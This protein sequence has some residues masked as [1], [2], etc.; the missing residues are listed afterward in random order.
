MSL[1]STI[2][3]KLQT[4]GSA[5]F[6]KMAD[7]YLRRCRPWPLHS[8][9]LM[10]GA[11]K[12]KTGVP[13]SYC[14]LDEE[15]RYVLVAY[16]TT[17]KG[18]LAAKLAK[19]L[20]DCITEAQRELGPDDVA[21]I[22]LVCNNR[23]S[24]ATYAALAKQAHRY[25]FEFIGVD[26]LVQM[27]LDYPALAIPYLDLD[28]GRGQLLQAPEFVAAYGSQLGATPLT[29]PL[30]GRDTEQQQLKAHLAKQEVVLV[31][32]AAGVGKTQLVVTVAQA[33]C[34][35]HPAHRQL[36]FVHDKN[37]PDF[38]K[39]LQFLFAPGKELVV[40]A[41]DANRVSPHLRT[42]LAEQRIRPA[43]QLKIVA[44]VRDYARDVVRQLTAES[45][46]TELHLDRLSNEHITALLETY[47]IRNAAYRDRIL[48]LSQGRPRLAVMAAIAA[49]KSQS[50]AS[51][52]DIADIYK[53]YFGPILHHLNQQSNALLQQKALALLHL[54]GSI[55]RDD[56]ERLDLIHHAFGISPTALW[57]TLVILNSTE[58]AE[59]LEGRVARPAD[60]ILSNYLFYQVFFGDKP[61]LSF[62][63]LLVSF[64]PAWSRRIKDA[65]VP[66]INDFNHQ[67][68]ESKI[69][70]ALTN[71]LAQPGIE[72]KDR[73]LFYDL[74]W[75]YLRTQILSSAH[76]FLAGL[77]WL[78]QPITAYK[79]PK[80]DH[81]PYIHKS[82]VL[83][84]LEP[85][86]ESPIDEQLL[87][88]AL[89][90]ELAA[91]LPEQF[92]KVVGLLR[93]L[94]I[95]DGYE[96]GQHRLHTPEL[97]L[98][99]LADISKDKQQGRFA[100]WLLQYVVP[101]ALATAT[102]GVRSGVERGSIAMCMYTV[103][104]QDDTKEWR[105]Q[106]WQ[107]FNRLCAG[108]PARIVEMFGAYLDQRQDIAYIES[109]GSELEYN[110]QRWD[111]HFILPLLNQLDPG[112]FA[113]SRLV[114][115]YY[116]WLERRTNIPEVQPL[117]SR[118]GKGLVPLYDL[119]VFWQSHRSRAGRAVSR[120][121]DEAEKFM[122]ERLKPLAYKTL[123]PY[124]KLIARIHDLV[125][126]LDPSE[127]SQACDAYAA[128]LNEVIIRDRRLG[129]AVLRHLI[130]TG[131]PL[132]LT[133]WKALEALAATDLETG[134]Q[135][136]TSYKY[137]SRDTW[138][139]IFTSRL[140]AENVSKRWLFEL[141]KVV[142]GDLP[143]YP[144][145][146]LKAYERIAP[147]LYP[148]LLTRVLKR[149]KKNKK[150]V[151][152]YYNFNEEFAPHFTS[153]HQ[154]L[155][156]D[157]YL[158]QC[159]TQDSFDSDG[160]QLAGL[161]AHEHEFLVRYNRVNF[162]RRGYNTRY[163]SRRMTLLWESDKYHPQLYQMLADLSAHYTRF[164][165]RDLADAFFPTSEDDAQR[166]VQ[167]HFLLEA[168]IHFRDSAKVMRLLFTLIREQ[169]PDKLM[170]YFGQLLAV[171]PD[172][173]E[174]YESINFFPSSRTAGRSWVPVLEDDK[175]RW[176]EILTVI[177]AQPKGTAA[178]RKYQL[179]VLEEIEF[180][181]RQISAEQE[182]DFASP[183]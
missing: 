181:N 142:E 57:D 71:W 168:I 174:L 73:W 75:P 42:L 155:L 76:A 178:L 161:V 167:E 62:S 122:R 19:D 51:L 54:F 3:A 1:S 9:G 179:R 98:R 64:F 158:W 52:H 125:P 36:F 148:Q 67:A 44:T 101:Q 2:E 16:T 85:L 38:T 94:T 159:S 32:G 79:L 43:G 149:A 10:V 49:K 7:A 157:L 70:P 12:D 135:L 137:E 92:G 72:D 151:N 5:T 50:L 27:I 93:K 109:K 116:Y 182:K 17:A 63:S 39:D 25:Q 172:N 61:L 113:H 108:D 47:G 146:I 176:N 77:P 86:C 69:K 163:D 26:E 180:L 171:V 100:L 145:H 127:V 89:V 23:I 21:R 99:T 134:Y 34:A 37:S 126:Q 105:L 30:F 140:P 150:P 121:E 84:A 66:I 119:L 96:Y 20:A 55:R 138:R 147:D 81:S 48:V 15:N 6:Q 166:A 170:H 4:L 175:H 22:V 153:I 78:D 87:A 130:S 82:P 88:L 28:L 35:E 131:N 154:P 115:R 46:T 103:P 11:D 173:Q 118:F 136:I 14:R 31:T 18:K 41:D 106:L 164:E 141:Y 183:Y 169:M 152:L 104:F 8:W 143:R 129:I 107:E 112:N 124:Q 120:H 123:A 13:D 156:Q 68:L 117:K 90:V 33:Y 102:Q 139:W 29:N 56:T 97:V 160:E 162:K 74:F 132:T 59:M 58:L 24:A 95:F 133:P 91:K 111:A 80:N 45:H 65:V 165:E 144:F 60:Q 114:L 53:S 128:L 83:E 40:V 177:S 110:W